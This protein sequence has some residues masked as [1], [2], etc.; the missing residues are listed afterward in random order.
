MKKYKYCKCC[1]TKHKPE[2]DICPNCGAKLNEKLYSNRIGLPIILS[3]VVTG[4]LYYF[5]NVYFIKN[6][7]RLLEFDFIF[8]IIFLIMMFH[9]FRE[10]LNDF[11]QDVFSFYF[12]ILVFFARAFHFTNSIGGS[13]IGISNY[14]EIRKTLI[15]V[16]RNSDNIS[17]NKVFY[18]LYYLGIICLFL[19]I[20]NYAYFL[21][22]NPILIISWLVLTILVPTIWLLIGTDIL[23]RKK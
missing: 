14:D 22:V 7:I 2:T 20:H 6:G 23:E 18:S 5:R 15:T 8:V 9:Y 1:N 11:R 21:K 19:V 12:S 13:T 16:D 4:I 17:S 10:V 3:I